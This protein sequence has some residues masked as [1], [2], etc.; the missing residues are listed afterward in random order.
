MND[1][2]SRFSHAAWLVITVLLGLTLFSLVMKSWILFFLLLGALLLIGVN[3]YRLMQQAEL[4]ERKLESAEEYR[5]Q[6]NEFENKLNE[7]STVLAEK[8][9]ESNIQRRITHAMTSTMELDRILKIILES[10]IKIL[11]HDRA[12]LLLLDEKKKSLVCAQSVNISIDRSQPPV[13]A[14]NKAISPIITAIREARPLIISDVS[15]YRN[16]LPFLVDEQADIPDQ[17]V[18]IPL[19]AKERVVGIVIVDH[20]KTKR[21]FEEE[22]LRDL[23]SYTQQAGITVLNA[24][25]YQTEKKFH[26][27]LKEEVDKARKELLDAQEQLIQTERLAAL[28][29]MAAVVAHEVKNPMASIR[30]CAQTIEKSISGGKMFNQKYLHY[31]NTEI[32]RLD[33]IVKS[34]LAYSRPPD[35]RLLPFNLNILVSETIDFMNKEF[36]KEKIK[37]QIQQDKKIPQVMIDPEQTKQVLINILDNSIHFLKKRDEKSIRITTTTH[38]RGALLSIEDTGG[39]IEPNTIHKIFDPFFTTK[40]QG[41][42]LGLAICRKLMDAQKGCISIHNRPNVGIRVDMEFKEAKKT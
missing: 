24:R 28:G 8:I 4:I 41:T 21:P 26:I 6:I 15:Q 12:V 27:A 14:L 25:L 34:I 16:E 1:I 19:V 5:Y 17:C 2:Q 37:I 31:I 20:M 40:T 32:D 38:S 18:I 13:L 9:A 29:E 30:A 3:Q 22:D 11:H 36:Q 10:V 35:P 33:T 23:I 42:G 7:K 39:G